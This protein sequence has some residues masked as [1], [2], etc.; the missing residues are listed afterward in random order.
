MNLPQALFDPRAVAALVTA[1]EAA[2][3]RLGRPATFMEV[4]GTHTHAVA[5]AGLRRM[6]PP[7]VRLISG[8]GCPVC[9]TPVDYLDRAVALAAL[10]DTTVATFGDLM[11]VPSSTTS[12]ERA[13]A[14]GHRIEVV[15]SPR[16]ALDLARRHPNVRVVFLAVGFE[17][18]VP[19]IAGALAEA[20]A[21]GV[22]NFL[23]LPGN[24]VMPPPMRALASDPE[25]GVDAFLLPGHVSVI[26]GADAFRFL[27]QDHGI[28]GAVVGF[29]PTDVLRGVVALLERLAAGEPG[30]LNL[31]GR[32]VT[33]AGNAT[34]RAVVERF[35]TPA[36]SAWRGFGVIEGSGLELRPEYAHRDASSIPVELPP[37]AEPVGCRC[38][39]VLRG[40][41]DPPA[42]PLFDTTCT[43][44]NPVGAC[45]VS[46]EG[47]CAAWHR[48]GLAHGGADGV[49]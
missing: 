9:V 6:L 40:A 36:A 34:A 1:I 4:C 5:A 29:T 7:S 18:T 43:P 28:S 47:T 25:L 48:H 37:P 35:F 3:D 33:A 41:V 15:Y 27:A 23:V 39:D 38:G 44:D 30:L 42:C 21:G 20:E 16:D 46:S 22:P 32:V 14:A 31:Y 49:L 17:T 26:V 13:R 2:A 19:T 45:M 10:P 11:R 8:P 24:K 12:L